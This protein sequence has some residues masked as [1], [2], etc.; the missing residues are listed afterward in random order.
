MPAVKKYGLP[1][2]VRSDHG[3]E[4]LFIAVL[5]NSIRGLNRGSHITGRSVHNQ[6]IERLWV[7][8]YSQVISSFYEEFYRLEDER[9]L[10]PNNN[11]HRFIL[12]NLYLPEINAK[13]QIFLNA[14]NNHR[15]RTEHNKTP[16]QLWID[17]FLNNINSEYTAIEELTN[18]HMDLHERL[19]HIFTDQYGP[20]NNILSND[21]TDMSEYTSEMQLSEEQKT[22]IDSIKNSNLTLAEKYT[23]CIRYMQ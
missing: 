20:N 11:T 16:S 17:G 10:D 4:N 18:E 21:L 1:S 7:D 13:L 23:S 3:Y 8:V 22:F 5:M 2:R 9:I 12:Q 6:R 15:I 19:E 14:W